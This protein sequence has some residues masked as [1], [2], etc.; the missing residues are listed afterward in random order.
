VA[1][2]GTTAYAAAR[3]GAVALARFGLIVKG[4]LQMLVG[5]LSLGAAF[6]IRHGRVTDAPGALLALAHQPFGRPLVFLLAIGVFAY[7][8]YRLFQGVFDPLRRPRTPLTAFFRVG[9]VLSGVG[10]V[11]LGVGAARLFIG[12]RSISSDVR[13]RYL[14]AEALTLP[15]G[16]KLLV[17]FAAVILALAGLFLARAVMVRN[18]CGDLLTERMSKVACHTGA[19][20]IRFAS[21]V[22][23]GLFGTMSWLFFRAAQ[24]H[25]AAHVRG[26]GGVLRFINARQGAA[27]LALIALGFVAM[28]GTSLLEARWRR[29]LAAVPPLA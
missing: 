8:G 14:T 17:M 22:Q 28:A 3:S 4:A 5:L 20:L 29:D 15:Y 9:D 2:G 24:L 23:A 26:M 10:Y 11:L 13:S 25:T 12:L 16:P 21:V 27:V 18:V 6:G 7:A 1:G 19:L